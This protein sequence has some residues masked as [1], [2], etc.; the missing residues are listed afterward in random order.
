MNRLIE[1]LVYSRFPI[2]VTIIFLYLVTFFTSLHIGDWSIF[3][4]S[5]SI[6]TVLSLLLSYRGTIREARIRHDHA[7]SINPSSV[8]TLNYQD[9]DRKAGHW[10]WVLAMASCVIWGYGDLL[11]RVS[12]LQK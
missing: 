11:V 7:N 1:W 5:G 9:S 2:A 12:W 10:G 6:G 4:R 3:A 8:E